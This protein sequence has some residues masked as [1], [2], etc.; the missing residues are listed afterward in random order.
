MASYFPPNSECLIQVHAIYVSVYHP[1]VGLHTLPVRTDRLGGAFCFLAANGAGGGASESKMAA[2]GTKPGTSGSSCPI[3]D[4]SCRMARRR[5]T[6]C[7][8]EEGEASGGRDGSQSQPSRQWGR[9]ESR[10]GGVSLWD[11]GQAELTLHSV[12]PP[13]GVSGRRT[14]N[15]T[16]RTYCLIAGRSHHTQ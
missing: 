5:R 1:K 13:P 9:V 14:S 11:T 16:H 7:G 15:P 6:H 4:S 10:G 2:G 3:W 12:T 8:R